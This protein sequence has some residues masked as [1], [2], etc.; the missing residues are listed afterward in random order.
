MTD[1]DPCLALSV[2]GFLDHIG[3][4]GIAVQGNHNGRA[5]LEYFIGI[6]LIQ[7]HADRFDGNTD[8]GAAPAQTADLFLC[9]LCRYHGVNLEPA[10]AH[11]NQF[12]LISQHSVANHKKDLLRIQALRDPFQQFHS[13]VLHTGRP[14]VRIKRASQ[15]NDRNFIHRHF[16]DPVSQTVQTFQTSAADHKGMVRYRLPADLFLQPRFRVSVS[17]QGGE[18]RLLTAEGIQAGGQ[19]PVLGL[20]HG[21]HIF[22]GKIQ[23][24]LQGQL[25]INGVGSVKGAAVCPLYA[26][27]P[28][29][30]ILFQ[31]MMAENTEIVEADVG[32][33][34]KFQD[35]ACFPQVA[36][37]LTAS[38]GFQVG[39]IQ[40]VSDPHRRHGLA[41]CQGLPYTA[42]ASCHVIAKRII[43]TGVNP[44]DKAGTAARDGDQFP[45]Q[46]LQIPDIIDLLTDDVR[47]RY[48]G[49]TGNGP[50]RPDLVLDHPLRFNLIPDNGQ[51]DPAERSQKPQDNAGLPGNGRHAGMNLSQQPRCLI[52][53][54]Q[55]GIG[56]FHIA[57]APSAAAPGNPE[58]FILQQ[59]IGSVLGILSVLLHL[60][61]GLFN[62]SVRHRRISCQIHRIF[63]GLPFCK[64]IPVQID[65]LQIGENSLAVFED[66]QGSPDQGQVIGGIFRICQNKVR[67]IDKGIVID[68]AGQIFALQR[69]IREPLRGN[70]PSPGQDVFLGRGASQLQLP[71]IVKG[72]TDLMVDPQG[73]QN[74]R[75]QVGVHMRMQVR[76]ELII[77]GDI[78]LDQGLPGAQAVFFGLAHQG[79][80]DGRYGSLAFNGPVRINICHLGVPQPEYIDRPVTVIYIAGDLPLYDLETILIEADLQAAQAGQIGD[81][82]A[83]RVVRGAEHIGK[84]LSFLID[85]NDDVLFLVQI[86]MSEYC[87]AMSPACY[88]RSALPGLIFPFSICS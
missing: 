21:H 42:Q 9:Q 26:G 73:N 77:P 34:L 74:I 44:D 6:A 83:G 41:R 57:D 33:Q 58:Q 27:N 12:S 67:E 85:I 78:S 32:S 36:D 17:A 60:P 53:L 48:I 88:F 10:A 65:L 3:S 54:D 8:A 64:D 70:S 18:S 14:S 45:D 28:V 37:Q 68:P 39:R 52:R 75:I 51:R 59:R 87:H 22:I 5:A 50:Q 72:I 79:L 24:A 11:L 1:E 62:F 82:V 30:Q 46:R 25:L 4:G 23:Q 80:G 38:G 2:P 84:I 69:R 31:R 66:G 71:D 56:D 20:L 47:A 55:T 81:Q 43:F 63:R 61:Q 19:N 40:A 16:S 76:A 29:L 7:T 49:I 35:S 13:P 15:H 86:E